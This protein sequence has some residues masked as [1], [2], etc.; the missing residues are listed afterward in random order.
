VWFELPGDSTRYERLSPLCNAAWNKMVRAAAAN[1]E[2]YS[3]WKDLKLRKSG[4][5]REA[6][7]PVRFTLPSGTLT[8]YKC[9]TEL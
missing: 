7:V 9:I 6:F 8:K 3:G 5:P 2:M 4:S 1:P